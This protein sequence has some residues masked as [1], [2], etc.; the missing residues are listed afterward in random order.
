MIRFQSSFVFEDAVDL[1]ILGLLDEYAKSIQSSLYTYRPNTS[2]S[3]LNEYGILLRKSSRQGITL[4]VASYSHSENALYRILMWSWE[5][6]GILAIWEHPWTYVKALAACTGA[7]WNF[8]YANKQKLGGTYP[9]LCKVY[10]RYTRLLLKG[11]FILP[12][13]SSWE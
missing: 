12:L 2:V 8:P 7:V 13:K 3:P 10:C 4:R 9:M 5:R 11:M 6:L 1:W